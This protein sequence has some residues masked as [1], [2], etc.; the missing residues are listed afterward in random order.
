MDNLISVWLLIL[1]TLLSISAEKINTKND[2]KS[3]DEV[4]D[5]DQCS[6]NVTTFLVEKWKQ[7]DREQMRSEVL[8]KMA[9]LLREIDSIQH[10]VYILT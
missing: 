4:V 1:V 6:K 7:F 5:I 8:N 3:S 10:K 9:T 2:F